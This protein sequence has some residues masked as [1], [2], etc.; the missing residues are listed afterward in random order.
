M[1]KYCEQDLPHPVHEE[2]RKIVKDKDKDKDKN[3]DKNKDKHKHKHKDKDKD[4]DL[5]HPVHEEVWKIVKAIWKINHY[6]PHCMILI[7]NQYY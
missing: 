1:G 4:K 3:K 6:M 2:V 7:L 5:S